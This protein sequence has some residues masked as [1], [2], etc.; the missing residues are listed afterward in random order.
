MYLPDKEGVHFNEHKRNKFEYR[1]NKV[2]NW[3]MRVV[4]GS[5]PKYCEDLIF[6]VCKINLVIIL[7]VSYVTANIYCKSRDLPNTDTQLQYRFAVMSEAPSM[8]ECIRYDHR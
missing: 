2:Q 6:K 7:S 1:C 3:C 4:L 8:S 5:L